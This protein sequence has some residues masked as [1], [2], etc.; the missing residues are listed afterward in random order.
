MSKIQFVITERAGKVKLEKL[1]VVLKRFP[2]LET[3]WNAYGYVIPVSNFLPTINAV[4]AFVVNGARYTSPDGAFKGQA[5]ALV[6]FQV[7]ADKT[8]TLE[9]STLI[10]LYSD[11][12]EKRENEARAIRKQLEALENEIAEH[13]DR[14]G[15]LYE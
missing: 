7:I 14:C 2:E 9:L 1:D 5:G 4:K 10:P 11:F 12:I 15:K 6:E 8:Y 3:E 13:N